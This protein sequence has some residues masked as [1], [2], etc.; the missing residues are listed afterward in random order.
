M[1]FRKVMQL[2]YTVNWRRV[3]SMGRRLPGDAN[4]MTWLASNVWR[5]CCENNNRIQIFRR[6]GFLSCFLRTKRMNQQLR[7][8]RFVCWKNDT[9]IQVEVG[10]SKRSL[11]K[12]DL[13]FRQ[14]DSFGSCE[15]KA[16][17]YRHHAHSSSKAKF[18]QNC[19][20]LFLACKIW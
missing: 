16:C 10:E 11:L 5:C 6:K 1:L 17:E 9:S 8:N 12:I 7:S 14:H 20:S 3:D 15:H 4:L 13:Y 18:K 2:E 19:G